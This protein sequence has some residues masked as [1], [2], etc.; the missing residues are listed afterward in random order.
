MWFGIDYSGV[1]GAAT[2]TVWVD[3][4]G[5]P[6]AILAFSNRRLV[7]IKEIS[8]SYVFSFDCETDIVS[9]WVEG[10]NF[11]LVSCDV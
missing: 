3:D 5:N 11:T 9:T 4:L 1:Q 10:G 7:R 6:R 2:V 8:S